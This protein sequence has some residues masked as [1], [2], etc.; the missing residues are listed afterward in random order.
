MNSSIEKSILK[1]SETFKRS[2]YLFILFSHSLSV[3][4]FSLFLRDFLLHYFSLNIL[5]VWDLFNKAFFCILD[6]LWF[7]QRIIT[8]WGWR[9]TAWVRINI[10]FNLILA[11]FLLFWIFWVH[12][13][14]DLFFYNMLLLQ[15]F[16]GSFSLNLLIRRNFR[17]KCKSLFVILII[18]RI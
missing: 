18:G 17:V 2:K 1:W 12:F 15:K 7:C 14:Q 6:C 11:S 5:V 3:R 10:I 13:E 16:L 9:T 8:F 4:I